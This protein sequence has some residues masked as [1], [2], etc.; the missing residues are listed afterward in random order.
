MQAIFQKIKLIVRGRDFRKLYI[1]FW[2][3]IKEKVIDEKNN[4]YVI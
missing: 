1:I 2:K 3:V 4:R